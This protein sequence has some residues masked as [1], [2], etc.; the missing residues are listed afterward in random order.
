[1]K[2]NIGGLD[3]TIRLLI[4][5]VIVILAY[6][7]KINGKLALVL[8]IFAAVLVITS[9]INFCPLWAIFKLNTLGKK[10]K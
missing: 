1:M 9:I 10:K 7:D 5:V 4:A 6:A 8:L 3:K 2:R